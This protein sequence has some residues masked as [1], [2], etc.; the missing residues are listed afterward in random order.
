MDSNQQPAVAFSHWVRWAE[1]SSLDGIELPG[2]YLLAHFQAVP[3]G[4]AD[5][6]AEQVV[7]IGATDRSLA[8]RWRDFDRVIAGKAENHSGGVTYRKLFGHRI[9]DLFVAALPVRLHKR[10]SWWF[11]Q[12]V[13]AQLLWEFVWKWGSP[14]RCNVG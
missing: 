2:V 3:E 5:P 11:S 8:D 10:L 13:E 1:R 14:P 6:A 9:E 4:P 7:Y 12:H